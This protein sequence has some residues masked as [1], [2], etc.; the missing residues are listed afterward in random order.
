MA[1]RLAARSATP[2]EWPIVNGDFRSTKSATASS[3]RRAHARPVGGRARLRSHQRLPARHGLQLDEQLGAGRRTVD[4]RR[5]ELRAAPLAGDR[6]RRLDAARLMEH[7]DDVGQVDQPGRQLQLFARG[8]IG[9]ALAVPTFER[10]RHAAPDRLARDPGAPSDASAVRQWFS[11]CP[12]SPGVRHRGSQPRAGPAP[13]AAGRRRGAAAR[14]PRLH[15]LASSIKRM[16]CF[17]AGSSPNH[18]ACS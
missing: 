10:L 18:F 17:I 9:L 14:T 13:T 2:R 8:A 12:P 16:S 11:A 1:R 5:V 6:H 7:L 4:Q 15:G 3:A